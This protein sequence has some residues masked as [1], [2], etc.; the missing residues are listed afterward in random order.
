MTNLPVSRRAAAI[1]DLPSFRVVADFYARSAWS[2]RRGDPNLLDFTFGNPHEMPP[3]AYVEA[4]RSAAEPR[5]EAWFAYKDHVR[6]AQE[7]AAAGLQRHLGLPFDPDDILLTTGGFAALAAVMKVVAD[8]GDEVIYSLPPWFLYEPL[9]VEACLAPIRVRVDPDTFDLDVAAI[10]AAIT[11]RTRIVVVNTPNNPTGRIYPPETLRRLASLLD[12]ASARIGRRICLL[13]DEPYNRLVFDGRRFH[14]PAEFYPYTFIAYSYGKTHLSPG[15]RLGY[16]AL[17]PA[18]PDRAELRGA[19]FTTQIV[20]GWTFPN[21]VMQYALPRLEQFSIDV[22]R[23]Q[24]RRDRL[25]D[26]LTG[27]GYHVL[28]P[29]GT[30]YLFPRSP[31][32]DDRAFTDLLAERDI[33]VLPGSMFET[34]GYFRI[35]LTASDDMVERSLPG[36]A[37]AIAGVGRE[38]AAAGR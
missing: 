21:A 13:S 10:E 29:E 16:V 36:F 4:L 8:P 6:S 28:R 31:I 1:R 30:F 25:V 34:P 20:T 33:F 37:A 5:D 3:S 32:A 26:A 7:A 18:M 14:S 12:E 27:M 15:Q 17:P 24:R 23:L 19:I 11:D 35:S 2:Q 9:A 38:A 22:D